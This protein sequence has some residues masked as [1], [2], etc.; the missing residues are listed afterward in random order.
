[1]SDSSTAPGGEDELAALWA[2]GD[3]VTPIVLRAVSGLGVADHLADGPRPVAELATLV[4]CHPDALRRALRLLVAEGVF[5]E[6]APDRFA[7]TE[8]SQPLRSDHPLSARE[9][10]TVL[11]SDLHSWAEVEHSLR[12]GGSAFAEVYGTDRWSYLAGT[13]VEGERFHRRM[14]S[15]SRRVGRA[16]ARCFPWR[17]DERVVDVGGGTGGVL[18]ELLAAHP[19]LTGV[20]FDQPEVVRSAPAVLGELAGRCTVVGGDFFAGVPAG[21]QVYLLVNVLHDWPDEQASRILAA[22][23]DRLPDTGR[24]LIVE[25]VPGVDGQPSRSGALDLHMLVVWGGRERGPAE[26]RDLL[27]AVALRIDRRYPAGPR[28]ILEC[29][30][31]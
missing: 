26:W 22:V 5:A 31:A 14:R 18:V 6:P 28:W 7:L 3:Y 2:L 25:G 10:L 1:M 30:P 29:V 9:T 21:G 13:P 24:L 11:P 17:G 4:G 20:L 19:G 23:R 27:A 8:M 16:V 12:T 15:A